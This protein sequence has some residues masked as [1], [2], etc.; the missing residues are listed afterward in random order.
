MPQQL[1]ESCV[2]VFL[3]QIVANTRRDFSTRELSPS[4]KVV[5]TLRESCVRIAH[6]LNFFCSQAKEALHSF[7]R[8]RRRRQHFQRQRSASRGRLDERRSVRQRSR[9]SPLVAVARFRQHRRRRSSS[10]SRSDE[11]SQLERRL[12]QVV[13]DGRFRVERRRRTRSLA[14]A[15]VVRWRY[16][17]ADDSDRCRCLSPRVADDVGNTITRPL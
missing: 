4:S 17:I 12:V 10:A 16:A 13:H 8:Q 11:Q 15:G 1:L 2:N 7:S 6:C 3:S 9:Q 5:G 14:V